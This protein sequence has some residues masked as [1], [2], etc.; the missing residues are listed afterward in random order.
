MLA[1]SPFNTFDLE[2]V[3]QQP[4][5][6]PCAHAH[7]SSVLLLPDT[8]RKTFRTTDRRS[9]AASAAMAQ[10]LPHVALRFAQSVWR[11]A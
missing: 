7:R 6:M 4:G 5:C 11:R 9:G 8:C 10:H 3:D 1:R 2:I